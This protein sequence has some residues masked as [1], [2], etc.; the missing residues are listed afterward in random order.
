[1]LG[2]NPKLTK[3]FPFSLVSFSFYVSPWKHL[4]EIW[5]SGKGKLV[6][7]TSLTSTQLNNG[8]QSQMFPASPCTKV[9]V[10]REQGKCQFCIGQLT[11]DL[12]DPRVPSSEAVS[13]VFPACELFSPLHWYPDRWE[14]VCTNDHGKWL[15]R[16]PE[17]NSSAKYN[18]PPFMHSWPTKMPFSDR[19]M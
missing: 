14:V 5:N 4:C 6:G 13:G 2:K 8:I 11:A 10:T 7:I 19:K 1:M 18:S 16:K 15:G 9:H 12:M 17:K 3:T